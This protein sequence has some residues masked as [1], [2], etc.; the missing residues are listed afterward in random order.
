MLAMDE[1]TAGNIT[2][3]NVHMDS[4][5]NLNTNVVF[6]E[7]LVMA[8]IFAEEVTVALQ[9]SKV[10]LIQNREATRRDEGTISINKS[11]MTT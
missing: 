2:E 11:I 10:R 6:V 5:A 3:V 1:K 4:T 8:H 9:N 7:S